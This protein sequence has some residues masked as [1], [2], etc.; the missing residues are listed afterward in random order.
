MTGRGHYKDEILNQLALQANVAQFI[1]F[2][3]GACPQQR[4][5]RVSGYLENHVFP[6]L[7]QAAEALLNASP[8]GRINVRSFLPGQPQGHAFIYGIREAGEAVGHI[9][10]L[11]AESLYTIINETIDVDDGGVSGVCQGGIV[12]FAP[13]VVPRFIEKDSPDPIPAIPFDTTLKMLQTV[14]GFVPSI[15]CDLHKRIEFSIHPQKRGWHG[16]HT[17]I[18]EEEVLEP[19]SYV[20]YYIWPNAFSKFLGDKAYGLLIAFLVGARVPHTTVYPRVK[21]LDGYSFGTHTGSDEI[22]TRTCPAVPVPGK[23][24]TFP[25]KVEPFALME[26][27]DPENV[28]LAS[29]IHQSN[30]PGEYSGVVLTGASGDLIIEGVKGAG[31][32]FML[33]EAA[34][35]SLPVSIR[36][37]LVILAEKLSVLRQPVRFEWVH[38]GAV[39][40]VVQLHLGAVPSINRTIY[41]GT[42][43]EFIRFDMN[44]GLEA[45]RT[46]AE[47]LKDGD[48]GLTIV[49]NIGLGSHVADVLRKAK[50]PSV[51]DTNRGDQKPSHN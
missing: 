5:S 36:N 38:D 42:P 33:G 17:I 21:K 51:I 50:I 19:S 46:L 15:N 26:K 12:E 25:T 10:Q 47:E 31:V 24:S 48:T 2:G 14:Y 40:W 45:L 18:W 4:F 27:E 8:E 16:E 13:G 20:P 34:P 41:P 35:V 6:D 49:G 43:K 29:C 1:S 22:W 28:I 3:P 39:P 11:A 30:V 9:K 23:Y 32:D 44:D 37:D 7:H